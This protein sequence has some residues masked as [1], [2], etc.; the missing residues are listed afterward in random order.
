MGFVDT[1]QEV[2]HPQKKLI[3]LLKG[4]LNMVDPLLIVATNREPSHVQWSRLL[5]QDS[6]HKGNQS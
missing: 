2:A 5:P 4:L 3:K 1:G 6:P